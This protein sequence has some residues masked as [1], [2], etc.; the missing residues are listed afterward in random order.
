[1]DIPTA[2]VN[3]PTFDSKVCLVGHTHIPC[4]FQ[5]EH[6]DSEMVRLYSLEHGE[7]FSIKRKAIVNPGS[8]GQPRDHNP[9]AS[10]LIYDD[11][12]KEWCLHRI[13]YEIEEVQQ[14]ILA[15]GLPPRHAS[16]LSE[17]W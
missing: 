3:L 6:E 4:I 16:R 8:V 7:S 9:K 13:A 10:Y 1:M 2:L 15:A 14:R 17:G 12:I 11:E 5:K